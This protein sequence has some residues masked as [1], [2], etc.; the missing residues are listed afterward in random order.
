[1]SKGRRSQGPRHT[2]AEKTVASETSHEVQLGNAAQQ[3]DLD[4][5]Y[6]PVDAAGDAAEPVVERTRL[7]LEIRYEGETP[8]A[9][10]LKLLGDSELAPDQVAE[11]THRLTAARAVE[12]RVDAAVVEHFGGSPVQA[13][14]AAEAALH[15]VASALRTGTS[16]ESG[17]QVGD[18]HTEL[19]PANTVRAAVDGLIGGLAGEHAVA[20]VAL[21]RA[22]C[23][24]VFFD[25]E[26]DDEPIW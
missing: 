26:E 2:P 11:M 8:L 16:T 24:T 4:G 10:L 15:R 13:R 6:I 25:E 7:A 3:A 23:D 21:C 1:M 22:L 14:E 19:E 5:R 18:A 20:T 9:R 17:W 12:E